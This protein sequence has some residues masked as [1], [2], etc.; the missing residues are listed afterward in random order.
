MARSA[1]PRIREFESRPSLIKYEKRYMD[2]VRV[3]WPESQVIM[4]WKE[5]YQ[6]QTILIDNAGYMVPKDLWL[7]H[8]FSPGI[9]NKEYNEDD[10]DFPKG[11]M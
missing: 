7:E 2:Y 8:Y 4:D 3:D 6:N 5:E 9:L 11:Y 1:K 10:I